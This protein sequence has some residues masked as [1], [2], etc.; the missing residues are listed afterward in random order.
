MSLQRNI[1]AS[2]ASQIYVTLIGIVMVPMYVRYMG[3]EAYGLVGFFA[4]LQAL[5]LIHI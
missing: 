4:M 5:S 3:P 2:F 1:L